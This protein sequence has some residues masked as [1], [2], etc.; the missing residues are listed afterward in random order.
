MIQAYAGEFT[1]SPIPLEMSMNYCSH[2]CAY[3]F[4]NLNQ[5]NR[6]FD[7]NGF[8]NQIKNCRKNK[9]L[10]NYL[11]ANGY[12]VLL[13]NRVDPF[14]HSN[15]RQTLSAIELLSENGNKI[16]FQTKGGNGIDDTL[17]LIDY[18]AEW[19]ITISFLDD[20]LRKKIEP[21][22]PTIQS[23]IE[24]AK[25]L[26]KEGH[27]VSVGINPLVEEWLPV[28]D[29]QNL[30]DVLIDIGVKNFWMQV[31]HLNKKQ[32]HG[33]SN[34][35]KNNIGDDILS[36][37]S[38]RII[39]HSY[40]DYAEEYLLNK[41]VNVYTGGDSNMISNYFANTHKLYDGKTLKT[42]QEFIS[43]CKNK[44]PNGG[45][46]RFV[47][48]LN[49]MRKEYFDMEFSEVDGF[50]YR[51]AR[52]TYKNYLDAPLKKLSDVIKF[53]W[54]YPEIGKSIFR[55]PFFTQIKIK[56][57][58]DQFVI[59]KN[60]NTWVAYFNAGINTDYIFSKD[61][62]SELPQLRDVL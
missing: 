22:S 15:W 37:A 4:A 27:H 52:N 55:S 38:K 56:G 45:I 9:G 47:D 62:L 43:Y 16:A 23:R 20:G 54:E 58:K 18:K 11:L 14:A 40:V 3:C 51:I 5:P 29:F 8:I 50:A 31:L 1:I 12:P 48:Y 24:L 44:L 42:T 59:D 19:Y 17:K 30:T 6:T 7:A 61:E 10:T 46:V 26:I 39:N 34:S 33:L 36:E 13:S 53:Y 57:T 41:G 49:Y 25:S 28:A 60:D 2:K 35:E 21:G 32:I